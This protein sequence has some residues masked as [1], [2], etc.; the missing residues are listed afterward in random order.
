MRTRIVALAAKVV[1]CRNRERAPSAF[2][3]KGRGVARASPP[4]EGPMSE[5]NR[6]WGARAW[7]DGCPL[8]PYWLTQR[9]LFLIWIP[10]PPLG[11][12]Q[13]LRRLP[14]T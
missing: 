8:P 10:P 7:S 6:G 13:E 4:G 3:W 1:P 5:A 12:V 2:G 11:S 9:L 14:G